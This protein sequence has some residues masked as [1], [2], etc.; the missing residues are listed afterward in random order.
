M[1]HAEEMSGLSSESDESA[2]S[3]GSERTRE[4]RRKPKRVK[5]AGINRSDGELLCRSLHHCP[6][7]RCPELNHVA[8][9][10]PKCCSGTARDKWAVFHAIRLEQDYRALA[11]TTATKDGTGQK[12]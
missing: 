1:I 3:S 2:L 12:R 11:V 9:V 6:G 7:D 8:V 10:D 5:V 4:P